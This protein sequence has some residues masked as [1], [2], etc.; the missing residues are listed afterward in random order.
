MQVPLFE[1]RGL[2]WGA[3]QATQANKLL[4]KSRISNI[5]GKTSVVAP[6]TVVGPLHVAAQSIFSISQGVH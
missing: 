2:G 5:S 4:Q 6:T 3:T 1:Q